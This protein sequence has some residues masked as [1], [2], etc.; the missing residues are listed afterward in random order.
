MS[1]LDATTG[2]HPPGIGQAYTRANVADM[3]EWLEGALRDLGVPLLLAEHDGCLFFTGEGYAA[4]AEAFGEFKNP[5]STTAS[6][7]PTL[8]AHFVS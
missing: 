1:Y 2:W 5:V 8:D 7:E 3:G 4:A 6:F